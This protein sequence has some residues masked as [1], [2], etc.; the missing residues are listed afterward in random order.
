MLLDNCRL[1]QS[2]KN[3]LGDNPID[4]YVLLTRRYGAPLLATTDHVA[5]PNFQDLQDVNLLLVWVTKLLP[6]GRPLLADWT[7]DTIGTNQHVR[8]HFRMKLEYQEMS[9][10]LADS[11]ALTAEEACQWFWDKSKVMTAVPT[12]LAITDED[13]RNRIQGFQ[14]AMDREL[15]RINGFHWNEGWLWR[16]DDN[17]REKHNEWV[18]DYK[19]WEPTQIRQDSYLPGLHYL[20]LDLTALPWAIQRA[21]VTRWQVL[22][23]ATPWITQPL[24][25]A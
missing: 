18:A 16:F 25:L 15:S 3:I 11:I 24:P 4:P 14:Y 5:R 10:A 1:C 9:Q 19:E 22:W 13:A 17:W 23:E 7:R 20:R 12:K 2:V 8:I 6:P 21:L